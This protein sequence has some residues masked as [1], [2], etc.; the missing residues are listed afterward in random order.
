[1]LGKGDKVNESARGAFF[2][3]GSTLWDGLLSMG[4]A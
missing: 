3:E 1:M 2:A 4:V